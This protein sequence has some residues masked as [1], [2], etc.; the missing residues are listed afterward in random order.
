MK[1]N[2]VKGKLLFGSL[3]ILS[4]CGAKVAVADDWRRWHEPRHHHSYRDYRDVNRWHEG[5]W[6]HSVISGRLG[7]YWVVG[8]EYFYYRAPVYPYPAPYVSEVVV[9]P[10]VIQPAPVFV[11]PP[12]VTVPVA[13]AAPVIQQQNLPPV[14][15]YCEASKT[16]YPYVSKCAGEWK[17]VPAVPPGK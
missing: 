7:W 14:W 12:V 6:R 13:P 16:Y 5:Y 17:Q 11:Q 15:Y 8:N 9:S 1:L 10:T 4:L 2:G 3:L